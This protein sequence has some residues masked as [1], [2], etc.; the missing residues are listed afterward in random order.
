[1]K[2]LGWILLVLLASTAPLWA[3]AK[4]ITVQELKELLAQM[5]DA[6]K[7][8]ADVANA[9]KQVELS[10]ELTRATMNALA[11]N[12]PGPLSTEQI[13]VLEARSAMLPPPPSDIPAAAAP[14][15]A[16]QQA[17]LAKAADYVNKTYSQLPVLTATKTTL[18]FQDNFEALAAGSGM[19]GSAKEISTASS[20]SNPAA[21]IHYINST[22]STVASE[23]GAEKMPAEKDK[24]PWGSNRMIALQTP[25]PSLTGVFS[26]AQ[27]N[28]DLK[29]ARWETLN[30]LQLA[31]F[32]YAIPKKKSHFAINVCCFPES[33]QAGMVQFSSA[34]TGSLNGGSGGGAKGNFQT[35]T[36]YTKY[37]KQTP[38]YHGELFVDP[39]TGT[40]ARL[41]AEA[42]LKSTDLVHQV[43]T[44]IDYAPVK[45]GSQTLIVPVKTVTDT[46][47]VPN[48]DSGTGGYSIRRTLFTAEFK[49]YQVAGGH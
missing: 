10:E 16:A 3:M 21:F 26:E 40:V 8:D 14:D 42:D 41:I 17:I 39:A 45:V 32:T 49:N 47:V 25:D 27:A 18:R 11:S 24:T 31:V 23:H 44:R 28:G 4:K 36:S 19:S 1:M 34:S 9:L 33:E 37:F 15:A 5:Q 29:F 2:R 35:N 30:G 38:S 22:E 12:V 6:K 20:F 43:D 48:G 7:G 13:Y 46:E